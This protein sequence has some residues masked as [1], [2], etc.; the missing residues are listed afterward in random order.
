MCSICRFMPRKISS[1]RNSSL[2]PMGGWFRCLEAL[3]L[4]SIIQTGP[5][6]QTAVGLSPFTS[7]DVR[8]SSCHCRLSAA[9]PTSGPFP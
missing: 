5:P 6:M 2:I 1:L 8:G 3:I 7:A 4:C 9:V